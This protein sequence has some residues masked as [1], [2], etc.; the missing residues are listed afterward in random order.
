MHDL[1]EAAEQVARDTDAVVG[2]VRIASPMAFGRMYLGPILFPLLKR[3]PRLEVA[4]ILDDRVHEHQLGEGLD[5]A[6]RMGRPRSE[7]LVARKLGVSR[8]AVCCSPEYANRAGLP[9]TI[10]EI[11]E[12]ACLGYANVPPSLVWQFEPAAHRGKIRS[13]MVRSRLL[14]NNP[15]ILRD[16]AIAGLGL[17]MLPLFVAAEA[18][19]DGRLI[20]A[21]PSAH[22][23]P[24]T[25]YALR[26]PNRHVPRKVRVVIDHLAQSLGAAPPWE[27]ESAERRKRIATARGETAEL[28][29]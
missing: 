2:E 22:P 13:V 14:A 20:D 17:A 28:T 16:G 12:H 9:A 8:R 26:L 11:A 7:S 6:V 10:D 24:D 1:D 25:I 29:S 4:L 5:M 21:L 3:H 18:L 27:T 23:V 19:R 15:E